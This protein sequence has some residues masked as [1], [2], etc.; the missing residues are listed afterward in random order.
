MRILIVCPCPL[1]LELGAVQVHLNLAE[2]LRELGHDVRV[3]SPYPLREVHFAGVVLKTRSMLGAFL[4]S[5]E[6]FDVVDCPPYLL[7]GAFVDTKTTWVARSVQPDIL[8]L[9]E[10]LRVEAGSSALAATRTAARAAWMVGIA[11]L[12]HRGWT[13]SDV[14][15]CFGRTE[16]AWI[17]H[18]FPWLRPK[19]RSYDGA[20]SEADRVELEGVRRARQPRSG[21][22]PVRFLWIARWVEHKGT[23]TLLAFLRAR[24]AEGENERFTIAGCGSLGERA[25]APL[26]GSGRVRVIPTFT[27]AELPGLLAAHDAGLF[28]SRVE[29]WGLVLN[30]M[31]ESGLPVYATTAGGVDDIRSVLAPFIQDFPPP[32]GALLPSLP[33]DEAFARYEARFRWSTIA[34]NYVESISS[35]VV[36]THT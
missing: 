5:G 18:W 14:V 19:L 26:L 30:E 29:G 8:Y 23:D 31:V 33:A 11:A 21:D 6:T 27:R 20:I 3:W 13:V 36:R 16:R 2:S 32:L 15:M 4:R 9:W 25:L 7:R 24:L 10:S 28:T 35:N 1:R 12:I 22:Q 34:A 17:A